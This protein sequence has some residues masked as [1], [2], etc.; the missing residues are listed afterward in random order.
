MVGQAGRTLVCQ[1]AHDLLLLDIPKLRSALLESELRSGRASARPLL[2][3]ELVDL[4]PAAAK[5]LSGRLGELPGTLRIEDYG[6]GTFAVMAVHPSLGRG[7]LPGLVR[8]LAAGEDTVAA[9]VQS[10][11]D[12]EV[13]RLSPFELRTLVKELQGLDVDALGWVLSADELDRKLR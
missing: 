6:E 2:T 8:A 10:A 11:Q 12:A 1:R 3:P 13:G 5:A 9:I 7:D 4:G